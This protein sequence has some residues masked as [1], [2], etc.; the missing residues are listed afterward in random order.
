MPVTLLLCQFCCTVHGLCPTLP[1]SSLLAGAQLLLWA[2][3]VS[4][5]PGQHPL[6]GELMARVAGSR[7]RLQEPRGAGKGVGGVPKEMAL[8]EKKSS[9]RGSMGGCKVHLSSG[10]CHTATVLVSGT[11]ACVTVVDHPSRP[12]M[13]STAPLSCHLPCPCCSDPVC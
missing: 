2:L 3:C 9:E 7:T 5:G 11:T 10:G 8:G 13:D 1:A 6:H 4:C 12:K